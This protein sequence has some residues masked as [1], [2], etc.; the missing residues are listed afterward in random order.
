[1]AASGITRREHL[2]KTGQQK[3]GS[4][5][6]TSGLWQ[7]HGSVQLFH[8]L[9]RNVRVVVDVLHVVQIF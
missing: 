8:D 2:S 9:V 6:V 7:H 3:A 1:M 5:E 4:T